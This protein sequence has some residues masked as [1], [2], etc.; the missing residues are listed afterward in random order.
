MLGS[1]E[2]VLPASDCKI[3]LEDL[4]HSSI[5]ENLNFSQYVFVIFTDQI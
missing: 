3:G 2:T 1:V 5:V 4:V